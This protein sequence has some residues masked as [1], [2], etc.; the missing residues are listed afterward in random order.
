[1]KFLKFKNCIIIVLCITII[2]LS[3]GFSII[4]VKFKQKNDEKVMYDISIE[5][6]VLSASFNGGNDKPEASYKLL[7]N[8]KTIKFDFNFHS[9][10]DKLVYYVT[11]KNKGN[12]SGK[13]DNIIESNNYDKKNIEPIKIDI[14]DVSGKVLNKGESVDLVVMV[15]YD[16]GKSN[17]ENFPFEFS[18][19]SSSVDN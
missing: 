14:S 6:V 19:L 17:Y 4:S 13:I 16:K 7:N 3:F 12:I 15:L 8:K 18:I 11:I 2:L 10:G 9:S 5:K 1:M